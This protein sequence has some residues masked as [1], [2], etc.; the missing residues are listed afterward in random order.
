MTFW[1]S[2]SVGIS[3]PPASQ[4]QQRSRMQVEVFCKEQLERHRSAPRKEPLKRAGR[5][6]KGCPLKD[7]AQGWS[8]GC[9]QSFPDTCLPTAPGKEKT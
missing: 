3:E 7:G 9:P 1:A 2:L 5:K 4:A 8:P 6:P